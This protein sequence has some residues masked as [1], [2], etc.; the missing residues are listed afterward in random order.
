MFSEEEMELYLVSSLFLLFFAG[1]DTS[2]TTT[3]VTLHFLAEK[4]DVQ[5]RLFNEISEKLESIDIEDLDYNAVQSLPYLDMVVNEALRIWPIGFLERKCTKPY[6]VP[7]TNFTIPA[8]MLVQIPYSG[9][10][11]DQQYYKNP[12][13][14]D[15]ENFSPENK[16][17]RNPYAFLAFGQGPRK[18]LGIR[19]AF[20]TMKLCLVRLIYKF[21]VLPSHLTPSKLE[22]DPLDQSAMPKGGV[23]INLEE[24]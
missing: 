6:K 11:R 4:Q 10:M 23:F 21:K 18:C 16:A 19:F 8:G 14:F 1:F 3:S 5:E 7:G 20:L 9:I 15:P 12:N 24:R 13:D 2:S 17:K 22:V